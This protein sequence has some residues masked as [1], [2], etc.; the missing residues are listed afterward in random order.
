MCCQVIGWA[1]FGLFIGAIAR[2]IWPGQQPIG[3]LPTML[4]GIVGSVIGGG[5]TALLG[6]GRYEPAGYIMSIIG[7]ILFLW[8]AGV[9]A[10]PRSLD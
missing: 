3:C 7:A 1:V 10:T 8:L 2:L 5:L 4:L 9:G 6:G